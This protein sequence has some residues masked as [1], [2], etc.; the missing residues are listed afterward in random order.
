MFQMNHFQQE[1]SEF[2]SR[3]SAVSIDIGTQHEKEKLCLETQSALSFCKELTEATSVSEIHASE[4]WIRRMS[5]PRDWKLDSGQFGHMKSL[6]IVIYINIYKS[7]K[8]CQV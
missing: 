5:G 8:T 3:A 1:L 6:L 7:Q 2:R 4:K